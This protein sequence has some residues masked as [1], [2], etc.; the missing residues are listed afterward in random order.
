VE[1]SAAKRGRDGKF[2]NALDFDI[3]ITL[4][5]F[6]NAFAIRHALDG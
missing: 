5:S 3:S 2:S 1:E 4:K 6:S